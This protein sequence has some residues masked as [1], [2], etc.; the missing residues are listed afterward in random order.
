MGDGNPVTGCAATT[1]PCV[2]PESICVVAGTQPPPMVSS[3]PMSRWIAPGR[4]APDTRGSRSK[5]RAP[6][7]GAAG[8]PAF[9]I[10]LPLWRWTSFWAR[11]ANV[12]SA[13]EV[14]SSQVGAPGVAVA[15]SREKVIAQVTAPL[16]PITDPRMLESS[17]R[18]ALF[19]ATDEF[20]QRS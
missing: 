10:G 12:G 3:A 15:E 8:L 7:G 2:G 9:R 17:V 5:S 6:A 14:A 1:S 13:V 16:A 19:M 4:H 20:P 11:F 18:S